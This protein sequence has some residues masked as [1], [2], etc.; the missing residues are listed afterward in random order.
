MLVV[1]YCQELLKV[2]IGKC[3][4][5]GHLSTFLYTSAQK[6]FSRVNCTA[7]YEMNIWRKDRVL[8]QNSILKPHMPQSRVPYSIAYSYYKNIIRKRSDLFIELP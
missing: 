6:C 8:L 3:I 2:L 4:V 5:L 1:H 7:D